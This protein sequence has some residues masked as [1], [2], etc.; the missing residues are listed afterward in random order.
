MLLLLFLVLD[1]KVLFW[2]FAKE[3][4]RAETKWPDAGLKH[5]IQNVEE[6][7]FDKEVTNNVLDDLI[8]VV[9]IQ[10]RTE[11]ISVLI[12]YPFS[13]IALLIF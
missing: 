10:K 3:V 2:V 13:M 11:C 9:F 5:E 1:V 6:Q 8:D 12:N 7:N 4:S